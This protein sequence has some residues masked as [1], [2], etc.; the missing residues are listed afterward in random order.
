M[1]GMC[2]VVQVPVGTAFIL[3]SFVSETWLAYSAGFAGMR[4]DGRIDDGMHGDGWM[5]IWFLAWA[6]LGG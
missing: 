4:T 6:C 3:F 5:D 1:F 2:C